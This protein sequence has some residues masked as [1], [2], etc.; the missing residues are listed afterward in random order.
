MIK[1]DFKTYV[2]N[3]FSS[4]EL[5][6]ILNKKKDV[7]N[8]FSSSNMIGWTR[9]LD[10]ETIAEI[11]KT[12]SY[13][14][15]NFDLLVVIGIGG[16]FLGSYAFDKMFRK[17]FNDDKFEIIYAG[18]TL[19]SKYLDELVNYLKDK[20]FCINVISKSGTTMETTI[21]YK[22]LKDV[23]KRK[24]DSEE[25][26]KHIIITTDKESGKLRQEVNKK[27]Y[28][29]FIIP[30]DIGGRYSFITPAHLLPLSIN[31]DIDKIVKGYFHGKRLIDSAYLYAATRYLLFKHGKFVENFS[32][33]EENISYFCEWLKQLFGETEGKNGKGIYPTSTI[34]TRDLHSLGQFIQDG[35]KILFETFLR[36]KDNNNNYIEYDNRNLNEI[37]NVVID[38][39]IRAHSTGNVPCLEIEMDELNTE[40]IASLIYF[41]QLAAAF[42][43]Y[44]FEINPFNQP[45]VEIYKEEVRKSLAN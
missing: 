20:N 26:K 37:N 35:N 45:G 21:T 14:K 22:I 11:K 15:N 32:V 33:D 18:T 13:I 17:Y 8:K 1:F 16:S 6:D 25:L 27:G 10:Q 4:E 34:Y 28:K 42:S 24:Y 3:Y 31:Y 19:S 2:N 23:L 40:N 12:G 36:V 39:V 38:S 5:T 41:F 43:G 30:N 7:I 29:S 44:L 9:E